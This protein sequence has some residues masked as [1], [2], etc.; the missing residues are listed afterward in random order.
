MRGSVKRQ[1]RRIR[2]VPDDQLHLPIAKRHHLPKPSERPVG[3]LHVLFDW[4]EPRRRENG[5]RATVVGF[6]HAF[7]PKHAVKSARARGDS[8]TKDAYAKLRD[9]FPA[10]C[11]VREGMTELDISTSKA[12]RSKRR[13]NP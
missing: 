4:R 9:S 1:G 13:T 10:D 8:L 12:A 6:V 5:D 3:P 2:P 11:T 7:G